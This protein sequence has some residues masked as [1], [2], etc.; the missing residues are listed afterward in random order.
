MH[1]AIAFKSGT[2]GKLNDCISFFYFLFV[3]TRVPRVCVFVEFSILLTLE[4][5]T[6][7]IHLLQFSL[8]IAPWPACLCICVCFSHVTLSKSRAQFSRNQLNSCRKY[9]WYL[10]F[11]RVV[12][13]FIVVVVVCDAHTKSVPNSIFR[14][15]CNGLDVSSRFE[16]KAQHSLTCC[17]RSLTVSLSLSLSEVYRKQ[18]RDRMKV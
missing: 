12:F 4:R 2:S 13:F 18:H 5:V 7:A 3:I 16:F 1:I 15:V 14:N 10:S 8:Q 17:C 11:G 6:S 9:K